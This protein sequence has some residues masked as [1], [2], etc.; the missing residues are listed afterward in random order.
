MQ[1][2]IMVYKLKKGISLEE[3]K[4]F[5]LEVDQPLVSSFE[6]VKEFNI[7]FVIG[8]EKIWDIF[9]VIKLD[10]YKAWEEVT[11]TDEM[12]EH[13]KEWRKYVDEDS[14]KLVFGE[15]I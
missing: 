12:K 5:S 13:D 11:Q 6:A 10:S 4:K 1:I 15:K 8:P 14:I 7:H 3:Y 9:E 2:M